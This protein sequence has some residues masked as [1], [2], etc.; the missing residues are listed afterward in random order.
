MEPLEIFSW[1]LKH[2]STR[3]CA[4]RM[5]PP[6]GGKTE[7]K[8]FQKFPPLEQIELVK[9]SWLV[10]ESR[11]SLGEGTGENQAKTKGNPEQFHLYKFW[12]IKRVWPRLSIFCPPSW[13]LIVVLATNHMLRGIMRRFP[14]KLRE[15]ARTEMPRSRAYQKLFIWSWRKSSSKLTGTPRTPGKSCRYLSRTVKIFSCRWNSS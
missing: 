4:S 15:N 8:G 5:E 11:R 6:I 13:L 2:S 12:A 10:P 1:V 3:V 14:E 9:L 7:Q